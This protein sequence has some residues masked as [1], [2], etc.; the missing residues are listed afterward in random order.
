MRQRGHVLELKT[1][2]PDGQRLW[3]YRYRPAG[4]DRSACSAAGSRAR[5]GA[6]SARA[7]NRGHRFTVPGDLW[8]RTNLSSS[9]HEER[10]P[11][12][13]SL[14]TDA[15]ASARTQPRPLGTTSRSP[16]RREPC[17]LRLAIGVIRAQPDDARISSKA[18]AAALQHARSLLHKRRRCLAGARR[19]GRMADRVCE[20]QRR[21]G[22]PGP[23]GRGSLTARKDVRESAVC[24]TDLEPMRVL[25][26][27]ACR[28]RAVLDVSL[29]YCGR[30]ADGT[31]PSVRS[32]RAQ[33]R[34]RP[35]LRRPSLWGARYGR[36]AGLRHPASSAA[37]RGRSNG[38]ASR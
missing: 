6:R 12:G 25:D 22:L 18:S 36:C 17:P 34:L 5:G 13:S 37:R 33:E 15:G 26:Q 2:G 9:R 20:R 3:A 10:E 8:V 7:R 11:A 27:A 31:T 30:T 16:S 28:E 32:H 21:R 38:A 24:S 14:S 19:R 35:G 29:G 1:K 4:R 23:R